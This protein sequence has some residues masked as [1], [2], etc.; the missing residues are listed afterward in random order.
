MA[1]PLV[2]GRPFFAAPEVPKDRVKL[3]QGAFAAVMTDPGLVAE[4]KKAKRNITFISAKEMEEV[5]RSILEASD[6]VVA[7]FKK[8]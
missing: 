4:A 3:L 6:K 7:E 1:A 8:L 5:H 2:A